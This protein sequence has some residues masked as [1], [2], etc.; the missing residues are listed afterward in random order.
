MMSVPVPEFSFTELRSQK[1]TTLSTQLGRLLSC[2][3]VPKRIISELLSVAG[4]KEFVPDHFMS[5]T[6]TDFP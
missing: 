3:V 5:S 4:P 2:I 6:L 1:E